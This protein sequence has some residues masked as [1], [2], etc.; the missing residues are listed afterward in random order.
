M[1]T[2]KVLYSDGSIAKNKKVSISVDRGG[3]ADGFTDNRGYASIP[4]SGT[5]GKIYVNGK[6]VHKGSLNI[7]EVIIR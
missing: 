4:V 1:A 6:E 5:Y 7:P 2:F 3:M